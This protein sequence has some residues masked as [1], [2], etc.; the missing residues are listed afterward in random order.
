ML[1]ASPKPSAL[2]AFSPGLNRQSITKIGITLIRKENGFIG[3][4]GE[5]YPA[6]PTEEQLKTLYAPQSKTVQEGNV[7]VWIDNSDGTKTPVVLTKNDS[8]FIGPN[9]EHYQSMPT[10]EQLELMYS[11]KSAKTASESTTIWIGNSNGSK[12]PITLQKDGSGFIGPAGE[13]YSSLPT[14]EQLKMLYCSAAKGSE[15]SELSFEI[16]NS[17]GTKTEITLKK[18]GSEFVGPNGEHYPYM[19]TEDQLKMIYGK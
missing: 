7:T 1:L 6:M 11:R 16:T 8:E 5:Y 9:G 10:K 3:P 2:Y 19:P 12:T 13:R 14:E 17:D 18:E 4:S 15:Q